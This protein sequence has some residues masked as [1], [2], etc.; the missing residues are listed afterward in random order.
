M[1][2]IERQALPVGHARPL[3]DQLDGGQIDQG[4]Q[5]AARADGIVAP[6]VEGDAIGADASRQ[7]QP[8]AA[9]A[10]HHF[11]GR[12]QAGDQRA[13]AEVA[14]VHLQADHRGAAAGAH[15]QVDARAGDACVV[16]VAEHALVDKRN[17]AR[18]V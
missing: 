7:V 18:H 17:R 3:A 5:C 8:L 14:D 1:G 15:A 13:G 4:A 9:A 2:L 10:D 6:D 12:I 16:A 11:V